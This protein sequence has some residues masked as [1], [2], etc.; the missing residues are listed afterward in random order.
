MSRERSGELPKVD[1]VAVQGE[2]ENAYDYS[3]SDPAYL[4]SGP[5]ITAMST[6]TILTP[7]DGRPCAATLTSCFVALPNVT[8]TWQHFTVDLRYPRAASFVGG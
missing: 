3:D 7:G 5:R 8:N 6:N 4:Q 1:G 2:D